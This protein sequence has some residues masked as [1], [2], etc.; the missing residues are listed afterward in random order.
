MSA[1]ET[2][3]IWGKKGHLIVNKCDLEKWL[4]MGYSITKPAEK[5][6]GDGGNTVDFSQYTDEQLVEFAIEAGLPATIKK[7]ETIVN[8]LI[9]AG[10]NPKT[11]A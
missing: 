2:V 5:D 11:K 6:K 4:S 10:F 7:R 1:L 3:H 8:K 9:E